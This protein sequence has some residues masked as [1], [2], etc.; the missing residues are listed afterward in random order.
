MKTLILIRHAK[1]SWNDPALPDIE[2]PLNERGKHDAPLMAKKIKDKNITIDLFVSSSATRAKKTAQIF[3]KEL[4]AKEKSLK[5]VASL[6][7]APIQSFYETIEKLD[8][9]HHTVAIFAHNPGIT[10]FVNA[11]GC[12]PVYEMPTCGMFAALI[13]SKKWSDFRSADKQFL[14]YDYPKNN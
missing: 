8:D 14:F 12:Y 11:L 2:R 13:K 7:E 6:Y 5:I 3:I 9:Q 4:N 10:G 1:S